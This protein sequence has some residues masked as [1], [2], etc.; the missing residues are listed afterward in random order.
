[1]KKT[2]HI[3]I[4]LAAFVLYLAVI[5]SSVEAQLAVELLADP[6]IRTIHLDAGSKPITITVR[7]NQAQV[8]FTWRLTGPGTLVGEVTAPGMTYLPPKSIEGTDVQVTVTVTCTNDTAETTTGS[9]SFS[10]IVSDVL[11]PTCPSEPKT[12]EE[13]QKILPEHLQQ[14]TMFKNEE[15]LGFQ[16]S[17][18]IMGVLAEIICALKAIEAF[19]DQ[20]YPTR[21]PEI[22]EKIQ[23]TQNTRSHYEK[24]WLDRRGH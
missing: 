7:T 15:R 11:F 19:L 6:D 20:N 22:A 8:Q 13:V 24:E 14:Y 9:L 12:L 5:S 23:K 10:L 3:L 17:K 2:N 1:M 18:E 16:R 21:P 4:V